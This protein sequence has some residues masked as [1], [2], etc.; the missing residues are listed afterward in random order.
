MERRRIGDAK[1]AGLRTWKDSHCPVRLR[2][3]EGLWGQPMISRLDLSY[4]GD[5]SAQE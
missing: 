1:T 5:G 2:Q 3:V 4:L